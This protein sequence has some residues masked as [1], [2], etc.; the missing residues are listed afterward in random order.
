MPKDARGHGSNPGV[1][2][3]GISSL[4]TSLADRKRLSEAQGA[5]SRLSA[6]F[7][8]GGGNNRG[9]E[10]GRNVREAYDRHAN[11]VHQITGKRPNIYDR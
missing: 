1:H 9:G 11:V 7:H 3:A 2:V 4:P 8:A 10:Y 6:T 5:M